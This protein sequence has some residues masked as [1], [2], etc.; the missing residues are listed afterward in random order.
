MKYA[1][2]GRVS[3]EKDE[4]LSS[5]DN[6]IEICR[7]W[8]E[9]NGYEWDE[10]SVY[11][12]EGITGTVLLD[13]PAIQLILE[14]AKSKEIEMAVFKS[15]TRLARDLKDALEM[16]E[17]FTAYNVRVISI[18]E[19]YDSYTVSKNDMRFEMFSLFAEQYPRS[20]SIS[21][22]AALAA[23]VRRGEHIGKEPFGYNRVDKKLEIN[24]EEAKVVRQIYHWYTVDKWGMKR[25]T[26]ELND[27]GIKP[28][29]KDK[30]QITS[31]QRILRNSLYI[32]QFILN[33]YT[34]VKVKGK[35]KQIKNPKEKWFVFDNHHP[36][37][38]EKEVFEKANS[39]KF[40]DNKTRITAWNE[41]RDILKCSHCGSN[42]VIVQSYRKKQDGTRT[43]W[44]Y[45]KCSQ[46]R[47]AGKHG[48]VNHKPIRYEVFR[49]FILN[50]LKEKALHIQVDFENNY[51]NKKKQ[52]LKTAEVKETKLQRQKK[53]LLDL[54][55]EKIITK[56]EL[57]DK[58][59]ELEV[60]LK[61][62]EQKKLQ[63]T[64]NEVSQAKIRNIK[65][66]FEQLEREDQDL[67]YALL[68]LID[69][70][71]INEEGEIDIWYT[72]ENMGE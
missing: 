27:L 66:A 52:D 3:T 2:Y 51:N 70:I 61:R 31:V 18:E 57:E 45:L 44:K 42:M 15:L 25:I 67:H 71:D 58:R 36:A 23:K 47:R 12:D 64:T 6:Q 34:T 65:E 55:L 5:I 24:E 19:G 1:V 43:E 35:K 53:E 11:T 7:H 59:T 68:E 48:C 29:L 63:L 38:I 17:I 14:K 37:I 30:W 8:L 10:N 33:Q 54:Y 41:F 69:K 13:R 40:T 16:R 9:R 26:N 4:Q 21:V 20:L 22:S 50:L 39:K 56:Q 32:G 46:Y 49:G 72:F 62:V 28:K 60:E